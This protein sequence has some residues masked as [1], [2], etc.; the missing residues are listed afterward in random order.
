MCNVCRHNQ[1]Q[2]I[3]RLL[4]ASASPAAV[5]AKYGFSPAAMQRHTPPP[6]PA[7]PPA[8]STVNRQPASGQ[9][10][11]RQRDKSATRASKP[12]A[13]NNINEEYQLDKPCEKNVRA[14]RDN[15]WQKFRRQWEKSG[16]L[17]AKTTPINTNIKFYQ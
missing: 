2:T 12:V 9:E 3:D 6:P 17:P 10:A 4:P 5:G 14:Q 13:L 1:T 7:A 15:L 11:R 8:A 16:K